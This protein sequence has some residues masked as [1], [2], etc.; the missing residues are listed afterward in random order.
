MIGTLYII[1]MKC[2]YASVTYFH[3]GRFA[4]WRPPYSHDGRTD[5]KRKR[6][7][8][9]VLLLFV[10]V[11][12]L[13]SSS[14]W[15]HTVVLK[16]STEL[17]GKIYV[18]VFTTSSSIIPYCPRRHRERIMSSQKVKE[19]RLLSSEACRNDGCFKKKKEAWLVWICQNLQYY[20]PSWAGSV[21]ILEERRSGMSK[22]YLSLHPAQLTE[23]PIS[24]QPFE[25]YNMLN[26]TPI[27]MQNQTFH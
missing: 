27:Q 5:F 3:L 6:V 4:K 20:V 24:M 12:Q 7:V 2:G 11:H 26:T 19:A 1:R 8:W 22:W 14:F 23:Y 13:V 15:I 17:E 18:T 25:L 9:D 10:V 16:A 21:E